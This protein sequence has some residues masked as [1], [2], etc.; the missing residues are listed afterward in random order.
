MAGAN[1]SG[2]SPSRHQK[3]T[4]MQTEEVSQAS[5]QLHCSEKPHAVSSSQSFGSSNPQPYSHVEYRET[6]PFGVQKRADMHNA[7]RLANS[8]IGYLC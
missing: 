2:G 8:E 6:L 5:A 3:P 4:S 7:V 1:H